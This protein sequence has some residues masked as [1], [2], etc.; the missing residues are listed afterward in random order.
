MV[1]VADCGSRADYA[2][3]F[4]DQ[5]IIAWK[6]IR[7]QFFRVCLLSLFLFICFWSSHFISLFSDV[8]CES[9]CSNR[10]CAIAEYSDLVN[11]DLPKQVTSLQAALSFCK[12]TFRFFI[13]FKFVQK[14]SNSLTQKTYS[15]I[16][17]VGCV[18]LSLWREFC[19]LHLNIRL[20][21]HQRRKQKGRKIQLSCVFVAGLL[22]FSFNSSRKIA[23]WKLSKVWLLYI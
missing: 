11:T 16:S 5:L 12:I 10:S 7:K 18:G 23:Q 14:I 21:G 2:Y 13:V 1:R 4:F 3:R 17:N 8:N 15:L 20:W 9:F 6:V 22:T 19:W